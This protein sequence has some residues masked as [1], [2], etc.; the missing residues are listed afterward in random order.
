MKASI[1]TARRV[2]PPPRKSED[3][4]KKEVV[5]KLHAKVDKTVPYSNKR[6]DT[7]KNNACS[8]SRT[9]NKDVRT[10][11]LEIPVLGLERAVV[12][13]RTPSKLKLRKRIIKNSIK[14]EDELESINNVVQMSEG[15]QSSNENEVTP[16]VIM[17]KPSSSISTQNKYSKAS[18]KSNKEH[19]VPPN[20]EVKVGDNASK[21]DDS[22]MLD[23]TI[24]STVDTTKRRDGS[25]LDNTSKSTVDGTRVLSNQIVHVNYETT[26]V[27]N[28]PSGTS[29]IPTP[30]KNQKV[31]PKKKQPSDLKVSEIWKSKKTNKLTKEEIE[32]MSSLAS[33]SKLGSGVIKK[34]SSSVTKQRPALKTDVKTKESVEKS[35]R[36]QKN[37]S[38]QKLSYVFKSSQQAISNRGKE[39]SGISK[40]KVSNPTKVNQSRSYLKPNTI[41]EE[42]K[43]TSKGDVTFKNDK[44]I[45]KLLK[46][47]NDMKNFIKEIPVPKKKNGVDTY[48]KKL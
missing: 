45:D 7:S 42:I 1:K 37:L 16:S 48:N 32:S 18:V 34:S 2:G 25:M 9:P 35:L 31:I 10:I 14:E 47:V 38:A 33:S 15:K 12:W 19:Q 22:S 4:Y 17:R 36:N 40:Q 29:R 24:K 6:R 8:S 46:N 26:V 21:G 30:K 23:N 28:I 11:S 13:P 27:K 20:S 5:T 39:K 43:Q 3:I 44:D 41:N